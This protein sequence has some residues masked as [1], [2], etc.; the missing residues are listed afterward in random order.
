[1]QNKKIGIRREIF[2]SIKVIKMKFNTSSRRKKLHSLLNQRSF[3]GDQIKNK[4]FCLYL[5]TYVCLK[6]NKTYKFSFKRHYQLYISC[7]FDKIFSHKITLKI[8]TYIKRVKQKIKERNINYQINSVQ[9]KA[10][11]NCHKEEFN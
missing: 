5:Y 2:S 4:R 10:Q 1:M 11:K 9:R 6:E 3:N 7:C 8:E